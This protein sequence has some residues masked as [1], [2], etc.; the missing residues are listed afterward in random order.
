MDSLVVTALAA[1]EAAADVHLRYFGTI[2]V[3][4]A[5]EKG[6]SDFVSHVDREAEAAAVAVIR[7]RHPDHKV[8]AEEGTEEG[9]REWPR[10]GSYLW[11]IDPLDGTTN[12]LHR[13][14]M[15]SASVAVGRRKAAGE[16][17]LEAGAVVGPRTGERW[18]ACRGA[19]AWKNGLPVRVS[20]VSPLRL[21]LVG[22]GFP[23][24]APDLI[25]RYLGQLQRVLRASGGVRRGGS[26]ALD[27]CYLAE[28]ILDAFWEEAYLS[29]WDMAAGLVI[30]EEAGGVASRLDGREIDL[31]DG[32]VLA[33]NSIPV[34]QELASLVRDEP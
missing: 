14:P 21:A 1:A 2:G 13:H 5:S 26:A 31:E 3:E 16:N 27:L 8:L 25:P 7:S 32:S 34:M 4:G 29:P 23:F 17:P 6:P 19:G 33:A 18:W 20:G 30:L 22:T 9:S 28:G 15:F 12:Y 10:D 11:I 24:R